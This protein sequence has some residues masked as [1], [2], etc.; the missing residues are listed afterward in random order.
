LLSLEQPST[1]LSMSSHTAM[2]HL[3]GPS[4]VITGS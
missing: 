1:A 2:F 4:R 3:V